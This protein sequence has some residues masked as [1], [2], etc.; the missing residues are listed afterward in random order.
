MNKLINHDYEGVT[1]VVMCA[2]LCFVYFIFALEHPDNGRVDKA[3]KSP[4]FWWLVLI[5]HIGWLLFSIRI[6]Q[7]STFPPGFVGIGIALFC[8]KFIKKQKK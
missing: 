8:L 1:F 6:G 3:I 2:Q 5:V 4:L 7:A